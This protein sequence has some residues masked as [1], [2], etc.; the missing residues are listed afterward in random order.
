MN[1]L[2]QNESI[3]SENTKKNKFAPE[4]SPAFKIMLKPISAVSRSDVLLDISQDAKNHMTGS[5]V[6]PYT[7]FISSAGILKSVPEISKILGDAGISSN[8]KLVI[9]GECMP[10]GGGPAPATYIYFMM[11][12]LGHEN[13]KV[14]DGNTEDWAA[15]GLST[16]NESTVRPIANYSSKFT[17]EFIASYEYVKSDNAQIVDARPFQEF[18]ASSIPGAINIPYDN[19]LEN[20]TIKSEA[21]LKDV[22]AGLNRSRPVVVFTATGIKAS[23]VWFALKLMGYEAK[24]YSWQD[25]VINQIPKGNVS[26]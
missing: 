15:S 21:A 23:V 19:V 4:R 6:I 25:W 9:Y 2:V 16:T 5:V 18:N 24:L 7:S 8:D 3:S 20:R 10:C 11:K 1:I 22:F 12:C 17:P 13:V 26:A 14:L